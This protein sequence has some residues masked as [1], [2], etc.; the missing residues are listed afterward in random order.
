MKL[1]NL[2]TLLFLLVLTTGCTFDKEKAIKD[3]AVVAD[4]SKVHN[5]EQFNDFL[6]AVSNSE[7]A[8][9][10]VFSMTEE[11]GAV[12]I[13]IKYTNERFHTTF[14]YANDKYGPN[15]K[16]DVQCQS[17]IVEDNNFSLTE[18][19]GETE[20]VFILDATNFAEEN[21]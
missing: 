14:D 11:G 2:Y 16:E 15:G 12:K 18:C 17:F 21:K 3:G 7:D 4:L 8:N 9:V 6:E 19:D 1:R 10:R 20:T 13:D 5:L